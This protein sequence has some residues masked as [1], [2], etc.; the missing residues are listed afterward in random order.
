[1][2]PDET[3]EMT[4]VEDS[5]DYIKAI[6]E[7]KQNTVDKTKYEK[8][9]A[10]NKQLLD[11]LVNNGQ[12]NAVN[13]EVVDINKLREE[14]FNKGRDLTNLE[15]CEK[16]LKLREAIMN[17]GGR[18]PFVAYGT[19]ANVQDSDYATA[20]KVAQN[21]QECIDY[22]DGNSEVFTMELQRR[23]ADVAIPRRR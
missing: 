4:N 6:N 16:A 21:L 8:L 9:K 19:H 20:E 10:E 5:Q 7:L 13:T 14:L 1:M 18:D 3:N 17:E 12:M 11:T 2:M 15:Y 22:A 23:M